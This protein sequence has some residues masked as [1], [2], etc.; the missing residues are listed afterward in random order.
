MYR[1]LIDRMRGHRTSEV[2]SS[3]IF[4][5]THS[6]HSYPRH[7]RNLVLLLNVQV[8]QLDVP[9]QRESELSSALEMMTRE[10][11]VCIQNLVMVQTDYGRD[12]PEKC[13]RCNEVM[14]RDQ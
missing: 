2:H 11:P 1:P 8:H 7:E 4:S 3:V 9:F 5:L 12:L 6:Q 13:V 10:Q 14:I